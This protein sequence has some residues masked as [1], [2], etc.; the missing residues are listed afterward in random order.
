MISNK[1]LPCHQFTLLLFA[2]MFKIKYNEKQ[3]W[4]VF[5]NSWNYVIFRNGNESNAFDRYRLD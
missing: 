4:R 3:K 1:T 5:L 2:R